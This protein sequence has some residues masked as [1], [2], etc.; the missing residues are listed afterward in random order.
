MLSKL[1]ASLA[2]I[3]ALTALPAMAATPLRTTP[4]DFV[5]EFVR[6]LGA[7]QSIRTNAAH[8]QA[9]GGSL[10]DSMS[11]CIENSEAFQLELNYDAR[12]LSSMHLTD[13]FDSFRLGL[14]A[15]YQRKA[16][17][18][19]DLHDLCTTLLSDQK[20]G[21]NYGAVS[22]KAPD[23]NA[24]LA[25]EDHGIFDITPAIFLSMVDDRPDQSGRLSRLVITAEERKRLIDQLDGS[26]G[27]T[28]KQD[29]QNWTVTSASLL[30]EA[31]AKDTY[32]SA[33]DP[34]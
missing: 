28:L 12:M 18:W 16:G 5:S 1:F 14:I 2:V 4:Y 15:A 7:D 21:F 8:E 32:K 13:E 20:P 22:A 19:R 31:L 25:F 24:K 10:Q 29:N 17:L 3:S 26:F 30:R 23:L 11:N 6:E 9:E 34:N 27:E 33:D